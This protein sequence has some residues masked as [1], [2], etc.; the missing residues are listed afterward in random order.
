[1]SNGLL[2]FAIGKTFF[3]EVKCSWATWKIKNAILARF[4]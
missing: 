1:M 3:D 2:E 4:H